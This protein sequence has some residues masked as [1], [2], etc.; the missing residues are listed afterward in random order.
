MPRLSTLRTANKIISLAIAL[1]KLEGR[2]NLDFTHHRSP[3][4]LWEHHCVQNLRTQSTHCPSD[5]S[6]TRRTSVSLSLSLYLTRVGDQLT[7]SERVG[8]ILAT[9]PPKYSKHCVLELGG[10][11]PVVVRLLFLLRILFIHSTVSIQVLSDA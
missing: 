8:W 4:P 1:W 11:A 9:E 7:G 2:A 10:K 5:G 3:H 6:Q